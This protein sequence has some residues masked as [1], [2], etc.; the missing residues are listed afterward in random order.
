MLKVIVVNSTS[1]IL[2]YFNNMNIKRVDSKSMEQNDWKREN[3]MGV[4][5]FSTTPSNISKAHVASCLF[6]LNV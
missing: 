5:N 2:L 3:S 1:S 4:S 6:K